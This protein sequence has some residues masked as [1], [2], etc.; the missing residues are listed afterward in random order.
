MAF[1]EQLANRVRACMGVRADVAEKKMFGGLAFMHRSKMFCGIVG[2]EL[3]VRV[4]LE[5]YDACLAQP[6][7]RPMD[8]TGR[9]MN[10]Y[11]FIAREGV[12]TAKAL[13][14]WIQRGLD[15]VET[16]DENPKPVRKV[17]KASSANNDAASEAFSETFDKLRRVVMAHADFLAVKTDTPTELILTGPIVQ[18]TKKELWFG[19]VKW[20]KSYVSLHLMPVYMFPDLLDGLS[21]E[22]RARM[23]G[24]SCFNFRRLNGP[25]L[26]EVDAL[27]AASVQRLRE[28]G[29][30]P[31]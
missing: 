7:V 27:V 22:L 28:E 15:F 14:G 20:G 11:V 26:D 9:P 25:L 31:R 8:F 10:G 24:K 17:R 23:Q 3:M 18:R 21:V 6:H 1:D 4:S 30:L 16:L 5:E 13:Q 12:R 29:L 2:E 19:G